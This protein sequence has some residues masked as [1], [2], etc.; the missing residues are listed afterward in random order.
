MPVWT[1]LC[2]PVMLILNIK[3]IVRI[4]ARFCAEAT[5]GSAENG[6]GTAGPAASLQGVTFGHQAVGI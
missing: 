3:G 1:G 4:F 5:L 6:Q 2:E